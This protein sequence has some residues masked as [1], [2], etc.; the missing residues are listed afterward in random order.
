M[1]VQVCG[2]VDCQFFEMKNSTINMTM[3][4]INDVIKTCGNYSVHIQGRGMSSHFAKSLLLLNET[5]LQISLGFG[6]RADVF[7][8]AWL[9]MPKKRST[10]YLTNHHTQI[11]NRYAKVLFQIPFSNLERRTF[12]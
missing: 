12:T 4:A 2:C 8:W 1:R 6:P 3:R 9:P 7:S 10:D 11:G 5:I